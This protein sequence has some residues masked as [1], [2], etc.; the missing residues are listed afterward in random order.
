MS[1]FQVI[2]TDS[3]EQW[4]EVLE[5]S[6]AYDIYHLPAYH[7]L[8]EERGE[9]TAQLFVY[10]EGCHT[11]ALPL[12]L[13]PLD[14]VPGLEEVAAG[15]QDATSVYGYAGPVASQPALQGAL[16]GALEGEMPLA[17]LQGFASALRQALCEMKVVAVF[18]RL[19][20][21]IPQPE[22]LAGLGEC[23]PLG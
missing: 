15:M 18:S 17:V 14:G 19:H 8:A 3:P 2:G 9:G 13:R 21:L 1:T 20:P 5:R 4:L 12:L 16:Q 23:R 7:A 11:I 10:T 6:F 22:L